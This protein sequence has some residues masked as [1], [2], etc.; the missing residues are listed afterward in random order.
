MV[1]IAKRSHMA[2]LTKWLMLGHLMAAFALYFGGSMSIFGDQIK[3]FKAANHFRE[4]LDLISMTE[5]FAGMM[6]AVFPIPA[7][8]S[9]LSVALVNTV[10]FALTFWFLRRAGVMYGLPKWIYLFYP[11]VALYMALGLREGLIFVSMFLSVYYL[12]NMRLVFAFA[13]AAPLV[14]IKPQNFLMLGMAGFL[15]T[16]IVPSVKLYVRVLMG[17]VAAVAL[18]YMGQWFSVDK[19]EYYRW[20]MYVEDHGDPE[21]YQ[22]LDGYAD[23]LRVGIPDGLYFMLKP[24]PWE[25]EKPIQIVQ[26][27]ENMVIGV[28]ALIAFL[29]NWTLK[30]PNR[31]GVLLN[32]MLGVSMVI[33]GL[34]VYNYGTAA[35]YRFHFIAVFL[36][37][38]Y[39]LH[40]LA[41]WGRPS[42]HFLAHSGQL[43]LLGQHVLASAAFSNAQS[44]ANTSSASAGPTGQTAP[45]AS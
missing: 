15:W 13:A 9:H 36:V 18:L 12:I 37:Y 28:M 23:L 4:T 22:K 21:A 38:S 29:R 41:T 16:M 8:P 40:Y 19:V 32:F 25:A 14:F 2:V 27:I 45:S 42:L 11:S 26:S 30:L 10:L 33:Y 7:Y 3:Y 20:A 34:V 35:R 6:L 31:P 1:I 44:Q 5:G 43:P 24:L 17:A 39:H